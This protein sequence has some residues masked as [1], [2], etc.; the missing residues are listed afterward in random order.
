MTRRTI[1]DEEIGLLKAMVARGMKNR[2]IQFFFN[3]PDR[4]D[5]ADMAAADGP[6]ALP[7]L[8]FASTTYRIATGL[9]RI[10]VVS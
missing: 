6:S 2:G 3:R 10:S 1:T 9:H 8:H 4:A 7:F 5:D